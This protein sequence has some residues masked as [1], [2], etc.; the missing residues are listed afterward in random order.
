MNEAQ[1]SMGS[2]AKYDPADPAEP[3]QRVSGIGRSNAVAI[4]NGAPGRVKAVIGHV[5]APGAVHLVGKELH[6]LRD[7]IIK[8]VPL[9]VKELQDLLPNAVEERLEK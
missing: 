1:T 5:G 6:A 9:T 8:E 4:F 3:A 7:A 2:L